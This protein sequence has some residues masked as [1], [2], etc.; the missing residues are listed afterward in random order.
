LECGVLGRGAG[1]FIGS[2]RRFNMTGQYRF[3]ITRE[4]AKN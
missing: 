2:T 3:E 4:G 1:R